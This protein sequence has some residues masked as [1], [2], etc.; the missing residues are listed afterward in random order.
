MALIDNIVSYYKLD[1]DAAN[2]D[3]DDELDAN[4]GTLNGGE[5]TAD[6]SVAGQIGT[7]FDLDGNDYVGITTM[8]SFGSNLGS[9]FSVSFWIKTT[10]AAQHFIMGTVNDGLGLQVLV[11]INYT[12]QGKIAVFLRD[13]DL[14]DTIGRTTDVVDFRDGAWHH[15][16]MTAD[17][18]GDL[19]TI[20]VD[21]DSK[22]ITYVLQET[23]DNFPNFDHEF[24]IGAYNARGTPSDYLIG[25]LDEVGIWNKVLS[26]AEATELWNGGAGLT[27]PFVVAVAPPCHGFVNFQDPGIV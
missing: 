12:A 20:Y 21:G 3:V 7:A 1:D 4:E 6:V 8:G 5:N 19:V 14:N 16:V 17:G 9:G 2:T 11:G 15:I 13:D 22:A 18:P 27:Y 26:E 24:L 25:T 23:A 10:E